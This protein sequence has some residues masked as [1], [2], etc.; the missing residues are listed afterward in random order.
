MDF[1]LL[2][3]GESSKL[4]LMWRGGNWKPTMSEIANL[5]TGDWKP[6]Q[7]LISGDGARPYIK[8]TGSYNKENNAHRWGG[9]GGAAAEWSKSLPL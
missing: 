5:E 1:Y 8:Y 6:S 7:T 2:Q 3:T 9:G 4:V